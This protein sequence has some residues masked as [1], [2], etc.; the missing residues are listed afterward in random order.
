M[1]FIGTK[2]HGVLDYLMGIILIVSPWIFNFDYEGPAQWIPM[3]LG[4]SVI[5]YSF[6]T[7]YELGMLKILSMK[8]HL[9]IDVI[10]GIFLA[11]SP[12]LFGFAD[13]VFWP[14]LIFGIAEIGAGLMT[15]F[16]PDPEIKKEPVR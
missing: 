3:I 10:S 4:F 5:L 7:D 2:V 16:N 11:V 13:E 14:H 8:T 9:T 12:W 6:I 1:R 15:K